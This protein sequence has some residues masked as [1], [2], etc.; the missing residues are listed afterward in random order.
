MALPGFRCFGQ[1]CCGIRGEEIRADQDRQLSGD[2][3]VCDDAV[4]ACVETCLGAVHD[5]VAAVQLER[6]V[7]R[8]QPLCCELVS[9]VLN[10]PIG[11]SPNACVC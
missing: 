9:R 11:L 8:L 1:V 10:P 6:I 5:R 7:K 4:G 2:G 3:T